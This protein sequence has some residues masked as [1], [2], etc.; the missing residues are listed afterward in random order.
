MKQIMFFITFLCLIHTSYTQEQNSNWFFGNGN[1]INFEINSSTKISGGKITSSNAPATISDSLGNLLFYTDGKSVWNKNHSIMENGDNTLLS[2]GISPYES[3][4]ILPI[5]NSNKYYIFTQSVGSLS[6]E[7]AIWVSFYFSVVNMDA[8]NGLG[9]VEVLNRNLIGSESLQDYDSFQMTS[10]L[11]ADGETYWL[12]L[13]L[14]SNTFY[15]F[16]INETE[17]TS[18]PNYI[19]SRTTASKT[20]QEVTSSSCSSTNLASEYLKVSPNSDKLASFYTSSSACLATSRIYVYDFDNSTGE[21]SNEQSS[22]KE[23]PGYTSLEFSSNGEFIYV[24]DIGDMSNGE[25]IVHFCVYN[26]LDPTEI[27]LEIPIPGTEEIQV[28][29][30]GNFL[31]RGMDENLYFIPDY[32]TNKIS[33]LKNANNLDELE[34]VK[35][36][37]TF[38]SNVEQFPNLIPYKSCIS[39]FSAKEDIIARLLL[40]LL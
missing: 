20:S 31:Q 8:N 23:N 22:D 27:I 2:S 11:H 30:L 38:N 25:Q 3:T 12:I 6:G 19:L 28:D 1:G 7:D 18:Y 15:S 36:Y 32:S 21:I 24:L 5:P 26:T 14:N 39:D 16:H 29:Y 9:S 40:L 34:I 13:K 33:I 35:D 4:V 17:L 10:T 37:F